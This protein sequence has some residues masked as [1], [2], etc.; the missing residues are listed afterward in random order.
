MTITTKVGASCSDHM[1][2]DAPEV[3]SFSRGCYQALPVFE[4][5]AWGRGY[6]YNI[7]EWKIVGSVW[8]IGLGKLVDKT[9][10]GYTSTVTPYSHGQFLGSIT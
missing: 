4:E 10:S 2:D 3:D 5:R 9:M 1:N 7:S 6:L 8:T